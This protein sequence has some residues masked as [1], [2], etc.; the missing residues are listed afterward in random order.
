MICVVGHRELWI[1]QI[2]LGRVTCGM[3]LRILNYLQVCNPEQ[4]DVFRR[5]GLGAA[6]LRAFFDGE[7]VMCSG[8]QQASSQKDAQ[9][10][11]VGSIGAVDGGTR[12]GKDECCCRDAAGPVGPS[13]RSGGVSATGTAGLG[14]RPRNNDCCC[15]SAA[16]PP[17]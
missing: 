1:F 15:G 11:S 9:S 5:C 14:R 7:S 8:V 4:S 6:L 2:V 13:R 16:P 12:R 10:G 3:K 17:R